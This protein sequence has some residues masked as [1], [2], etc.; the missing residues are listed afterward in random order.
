MG[1]KQFLFF[2]LRDWKRKKYILPILV[3]VTRKYKFH[4]MTRGGF[5]K[6]QPLKFL[7]AGCE[8]VHF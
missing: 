3:R 2:E 8:E 4:K 1:N 6:Y 5:Y 7:K